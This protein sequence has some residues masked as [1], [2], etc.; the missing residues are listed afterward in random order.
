MLL[1]ASAYL[2]C[3]SLLYRALHLSAAVDLRDSHWQDHLGSL[4]PIPWPSMFHW[5]VF[6]D[7]S[8][9]INVPNT[10]KLSVCFLDPLPS[11]HV[12]GKN[13]HVSDGEEV[14][15][16]SIQRN[17]F[18]FP[19]IWSWLPNYTSYKEVRSL[20]HLILWAKWAISLAGVLTRRLGSI[21]EWATKS[22]TFASFRSLE[23]KE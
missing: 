6:E 14:I 4:I 12:T 5:Q 22:S 15:S 20:W 17:M 21:T 18:H 10:N 7:S 13:T 23:K 9:E 3:Q 11:T 8:W 19:K 1:L 2:S 16:S